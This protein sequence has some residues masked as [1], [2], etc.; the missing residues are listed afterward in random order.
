MSFRQAVR[1]CF[2]KYVE[3][4]GRARRSEYWYF[5][6]LNVLVMLALIVVC[7][8]FFGLA[9]L[10]APTEMRYDDT[11]S[12]TVLIIGGILYILYFL[13]TVLPYLAVTVRRLHDLNASGCYLL[14]FFLVSLIPYIGLIAAIAQIVIFAQP[15][16]EGENKYGPDP[17]QMG[18]P[19]PAI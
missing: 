9:Y 18:D 7:G 13:A 19:S 12:G 8:I 10:I 11:I 5:V 1:T 4:R 16:T 15:G 6:L 2:D 17:R 14:L 3:D